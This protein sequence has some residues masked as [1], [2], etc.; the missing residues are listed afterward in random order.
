V[1]ISSSFS[2]TTDADTRLLR[3]LAQAFLLC[4]ALPMVLT[5]VAVFAYTVSVIGPVDVGTFVRFFGST[6]LVVAIFAHSFCVERHI[7]VRTSCYNL[8]IFLLNR[9]FAPRPGHVLLLSV[10]PASRN[11]GTERFLR[12]FAAVIILLLLKILFFLVFHHQV[13]S[14]LLAVHRGNVLE[15]IFIS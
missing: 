15:P 6:L 13:I 1:D 4:S 5:E 2:A 9:R 11:A 12:S 14:L 10:A 8:F 7:C 3:T